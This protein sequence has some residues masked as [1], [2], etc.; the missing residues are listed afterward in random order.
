V[1]IDT[2]A[3]SLTVT[4]PFAQKLLAQGF[5][6]EGPGETVKLADG[7]ERDGR[8]VII[9]TV[10]IGS[11]VLRDVCAGVTPDGADMLL[12]LP[13]LTRSGASP[14]TASTIS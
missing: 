8:T 12:G 11:H 10:T 9:G 6:H 5:A 1:L 14:S 2:G 7:S 4:E 3:T 13:L